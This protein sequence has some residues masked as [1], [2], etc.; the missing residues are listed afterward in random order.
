MQ[1]LLCCRRPKPLSVARK[2][3]NPAARASTDLNRAL[4]P[5]TNHSPHASPN[6]QTSEGDARIALELMIPEGQA[7]AKDSNATRPVSF[8]IP[9]SFPP[10]SLSSPS[11]L[12]SVAPSRRRPTITVVTSLLLTS[13]KADRL[14]LD[15]PLL[16]LVPSIW[17]RCAEHRPLRRHGLLQPSVVQRLPPP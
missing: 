14:P 5:P 17:R 7:A 16:Y 15:R 3:A 6:S 8:P 1:S 2:R 10:V 4:G 12:L 9:L 11:F 13:A